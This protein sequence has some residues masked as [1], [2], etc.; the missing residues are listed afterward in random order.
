M[1]YSSVPQCHTNRENGVL[2]IA[3]PSFDAYSDEVGVK[4][5]VQAVAWTS[6]LSIC[7]ARESAASHF[8]L[9]NINQPRSQR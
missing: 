9:F 2:L 7:V 1:A 5:E 4:D 8:A 6:C 3:S